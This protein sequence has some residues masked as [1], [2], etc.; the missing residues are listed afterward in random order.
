MDATLLAAFELLSMVF[1]HRPHPDL[2][3]HK[4]TATCFSLSVSVAGYGMV[5]APF[6]DHNTNP[7][8][9]YINSTFYDVYPYLPA[10][11]LSYPERRPWM[12]NATIFL[13]AFP[14]VYSVLVLR[15]CTDR[16]YSPHTKRMTPLTR[17][18]PTVNSRHSL[19]GLLLLKDP[20]PLFSPLHVQ[21]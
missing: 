11:H 5:G 6:S 12:L 7:G 8:F 10:L 17:A 18:A 13:N 2:T 4:A 14:S 16:F 21:L 9:I 15:P 20:S 19:K 1:L 3:T